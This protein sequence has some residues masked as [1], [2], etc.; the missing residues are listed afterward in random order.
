MK[1]IL[2]LKKKVQGFGAWYAYALGELFD[3][4]NA[5]YIDSK[6]KE[7]LSASF[8]CIA[9]VYKSGV[10]MAQVPADGT[11]DFTC[12]RGSNANT[13]GPDSFRILGFNTPAITNRPNPVL[14]VQPQIT[15]RSNNS[16][17]S[18]QSTTV[19][20]E[21]A[22]YFATGFDL[23]RVSFA[24][25]VAY[26]DNRVMP[27]L[28]S[29]NTTNQAISISMYLKKV[30]SRYV[31]FA[32]FNAGPNPSFSFDFDTGDLSSI[33]ES[34]L[35]R[36]SELQPDG[37]YLISGTSISRTNTGAFPQLRGGTTADLLTTTTI[38]GTFLQG[39]CQ[40]EINPIASS[41]ILNKGTRQA[42][43]FTLGGKAG[44][45]TN[46][47]GV[48]LIKMSDFQSGTIDFLNAAGDNHYKLRIIGAAVLRMTSTSS[49]GATDE[50]NFGATKEDL[51]EYIFVY[52]RDT[53]SLKVYVNGVQIQIRNTSFAPQDLERIAFVGLSAKI[54]KIAT[55]TTIAAAQIDKPFIT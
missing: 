31:R 16:F 9:G 37:G 19:V 7:H 36:K 40:V 39:L 49:L 15:N 29:L 5:A 23:N 12:S 44:M 13:F 48:I 33:D 18:E 2:L 42:D 20:L 11:A 34:L 55:Y 10:M 41:T 4:D 50:C 52:R 27:N 43:Q 6:V 51:N 3:I 25:G 17:S 28:S 32:L 1:R 35:N 14:L 24:A 26:T 30:D 22:N 53:T 8:V 47:E 46:S 45:L 54:H 21:Q 38:N